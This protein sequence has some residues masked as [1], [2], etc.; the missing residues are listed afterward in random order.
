[1][2][3]AIIK[4]L[5]AMKYKRLWLLALLIPSLILY[6]LAK[7]S[8]DF[9]EGYAIYVYRY[10]SVAWNWVSSLLPFSI[11]EILLFALILGGIGYLF[12]SVVCIIRR[13]GQRL[14]EVYK[15]CM[16]I[17][18]AVSVVLFLFVTNCG[19]NYYRHTFA[20]VSGLTM[21][22]S[23]SDTLFNLCEILVENINNERSRLDGDGVLELSDFSQVSKQ[24][25]DAVNALEEKYPTIYGGYGTTKSV[26]ISPLMC[27]IQITGIFSPFTFEANI[28]TNAPAFTLP[29]TMCH[30]LAH[31]R[32]YMREDE[33]N[34]IAFLACVESESAEL[35]YSG[36]MLAFVHAFN[37]LGSD[38]RRFE[39]YDRLCEGAKADL[40][41]NNAFWAKYETPVAAFAESV[42]DAYLRQNDQQDGTKSYGR[43][44]DLLIA[45]YKNKTSLALTEKGI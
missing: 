9:A 15:L 30:E 39:L 6:I 23:S 36:Y 20:E 19:V 14:K 28:N 40:S 42:N 41:Y 38:E 26:M 34:F 44:V 33:A 43:V 21:E 27:Q 37:A 29:T 31:L 1:M 32:G 24:A 11:A 22:N 12:F 13:K 7:S 2:K 5:S 10:V 16:N 8:A 4:K 35:R 45:Y 18:C 25:G 17:S 3:Q